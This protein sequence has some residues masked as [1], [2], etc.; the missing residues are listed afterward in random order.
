MRAVSVDFSMLFFIF[1]TRK[2][3][4]RREPEKAFVY[5]LRGLPEGSPLCCVSI[6]VLS[7]F[8]GFAP[9]AA[10]LSLP[11]PQP[12]LPHTSYIIVCEIRCSR[13]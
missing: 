1:H 2:D 4:L 5:S 13:L 3:L 12:V 6:S 8:Q 7:P 10:R 9:P 11:S